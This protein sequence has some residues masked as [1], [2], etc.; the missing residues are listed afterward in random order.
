[1]GNGAFFETRAFAERGHT[2]DLVTRKLDG[3]THLPELHPGITVHEVP[4]LLAP[5]LFTVSFGRNAVREVLR[6]GNDFDAVHV[7][8]N[9]TLI[10]RWAYRELGGAIVSTMHG[11]WRGERS[12]MRL[13]E[14]LSPSLEAL[15]DLAV[16]YVSPMMD[17]YEDYALMCSDGVTIDSE[18]EMRAVRA[19]GL[20]RYC[21]R[22]KL[23]PEGVD[24]ATFRPENRDPG[25]LERLGVG[26]GHR[27]LL[28]V[29]RLAARKGFFRLLRLFERLAQ[30]RRDVSLVIV[31]TGPH[32][33][34]LRRWVASHGL[35]GRVVLTGKLGFADLRALYATADVFVFYSLW[36]GQG[37]VIL[38]A[39]SSGT[40]CVSTDVGGVPEMVRHGEDGYRFRVG[41]D[42]VALGHVASLLDDE[43]TRR[44]FGARGRRR[45]VEEYDWDHR[46]ARIEGMMI[47]ILAEG[48]SGAA[49]ARGC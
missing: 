35:A 8:S 6:L 17:A 5:M 16:M 44:L 34:A 4:M 19:R 22:M 43:P 9:M 24:T 10:P 45:M 49:P 23:I 33:G 7:H 1:V 26:P 13:G 12:Q 40:P 30:R 39:M 18:S 14:V 29:S 28:S 42:D 37:L 25:V 38:E 31:G 36:E 20:P 15:N 11:T 21:P 3:G 47:D 2:I 48:R 41:E 46:V 32:E 27:V